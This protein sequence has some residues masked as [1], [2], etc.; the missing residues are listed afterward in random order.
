MNLP[1]FFDTYR[2]LFGPLRQ[3]QVAPLEWLVQRLVAEPWPQQHRAYMLATA[4]HETADTYLPVREAFWMSEDWRR[5]KL[6][7]WPWYGR[8]FVQLTWQRNYERAAREL[9][10]SDL[11]VVPDAAL[12]PEIAYRVMVTG[13]Q[14]GW[15]TGKRLA[16]Y[17]NDYRNARR[18]IN[19]LD[20]ADLVAEHARKFERCLEA[21]NV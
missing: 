15:F 1:A 4:K 5:R 14:Q 16:D 7:Y 2:R 19:G 8:G 17:R 21:A 3:E 9:G 18:I 10:L 11:A 6:R 12:E 13:M 20:K